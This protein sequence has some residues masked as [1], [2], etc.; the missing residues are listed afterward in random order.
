MILQGTQAH[1]SRDVIFDE[2]TF[3]QWND[4]TEA[5]QNP[6]EFTVEYLVTELGEG[7]AQH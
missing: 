4:V 3:W 5:D 2:C 1:V 6:N 7:G